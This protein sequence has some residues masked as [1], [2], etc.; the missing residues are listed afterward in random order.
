MNVIE[1]Q[2]REQ[3]YARHFE[4]NE[5]VLRTVFGTAESL[6][7]YDTL[8][9]SDYSTVVAPRFDFEKK[10][11]RRASVFPTDC[12]RAFDMGMRFAKGNGVAS[13]NLAP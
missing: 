6:F 1:E 5:R 4:A 12:E 3:D 7:S 13:R 8:Q 10:S 9:F 11:K 2:M